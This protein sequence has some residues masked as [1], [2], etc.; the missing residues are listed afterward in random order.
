MFHSR[1]TTGIKALLRWVIVAVVLHG[2]RRADSTGGV[3]GETGDAAS[4]SGSASGAE[5]GVSDANAGP[6]TG[7]E[8]AGTGTS[9]GSG[10]TSCD[11]RLEDVQL[12]L[13]LDAPLGIVEQ[14]D[15]DRDGLMDVFGGRGV[16][17]FGG[18][19]EPRT[20]TEAP[21]G[22]NGQPADLDGDSDVDV[23]F[24]GGE[25]RAILGALTDTPAV[26]STPAPAA[27]AFDVADYDAD[28]A[29]DVA[30]LLADTL[31]RV[32]IWRSLDTGAFEFAIAFDTRWHFGNLAFVRYGESQATAIAYAGGGSN[33]VDLFALTS[34][35]ATRVDG[36]EVLD[37]F[38]VLGFRPDATGE[39]ALLL[40]SWYSQLITLS[41]VSVARRSPRT[42]EWS[43]VDHDL[44]G[45][46]PLDATPVDADGDGDADVA[47]LVDGGDVRRL[48]I[49]CVGEMSF[50]R[51]A[52]MELPL[53]MESVGALGGD[54][55]RLVVA[56]DAATWRLALP[57]V[58]CP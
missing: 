55:V 10:P 31:G 23:L 9:T 11:R 47:V 52:W 16:A 50:E 53:P 28:G 8:T 49:V 2:C 3:T 5:V 26:V 48:D 30:L 39:E 37:A 13:V 1:S 33:L 45:A 27:L 46:F 44:G 6:D 51:C 29:S 18:A 19:S 40:S 42:G 57:P 34:N 58:G 24:A 54:S 12:E 20:L 32:E 41:S 43:V 7:D 38:R 15:L 22:N 36:F 17:V 25:I 56:D 4:G 21:R 14:Y 35:S